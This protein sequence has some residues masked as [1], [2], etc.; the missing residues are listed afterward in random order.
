M[1][2]EKNSKKKNHKSNSKKVV[3]NTKEDL[4]KLSIS[5]L[6]NTKILDFTGDYFDFIYQRALGLE[7]NPTEKESLLTSNSLLVNKNL[8]KKVP[9]KDTSKAAKII[10]TAK[11][12]AK[13]ITNISSNIQKKK[14]EKKNS[15][16]TSINNN[17][18]F[19]QDNY[20]SYNNS[21]II[22]N[23]ND[24]S[25]YENQSLSLT[26]SNKYNN[27]IGMQSLVKAL[28]IDK[29]V[30]QMKYNTL[31]GEDLGVIGSIEELGM[32]DQNKALKLV[33]NNG[34]VWK[35]KINFNFSR[36]NSFEFKFIFISNGRVKQWEDGSNRKLIY[37]QLKEMVE[38]NIKEGY[39]VEL[40]NVNGNNIIYNHKDSSLTVVCDWNK[41]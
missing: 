1:K 8:N 2:E 37:E 18:F 16:N 23:N 5:I 30:F 14:E 35:T 4:N 41:K 10:K 26:S 40:K 28:K 17:V 15:A 13:K 32:W 12:A 21:N 3:I 11:K 36:T 27:D 34:N 7:K 6:K 39:L 33:W 24:I 25:E 31:P 20:N 22:N 19:N 29:I 38:P 9:L